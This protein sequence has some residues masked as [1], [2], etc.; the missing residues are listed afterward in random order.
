MSDYVKRTIVKE[1]V[2]SLH[3]DTPR[4]VKVY[5]PP[6]YNELLSY[7]VVYCQDGNDFFTMGRIATIANQLILE[8]GVEPFLIVGVS[9]ERSKRTSEYSPVGSRHDGYKRFFTDELLPYIEE[10][11]PVRRDPKSRVLAGD[12]LG[13]TVSLH[14][15]LDRPDLFTRV[16]SL[17]G[18]FFQPTLDRIAQESTLSWLDIWMVVGLEETAVETHIGTFDFVEWNRAA[19]QSLM[20]K[21]AAVSY[22]EKPGNHVWGLWQKEL[23]DGLRHFFPALPL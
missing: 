10:R 3:V 9:V 19:R 16:L 12:S 1:E 20:E 14:I 17:S 22:R 13:G 11:Y 6:G 4:S 15:A 2:P 8:D 7:P 21:H 5:L 23:P 18:A